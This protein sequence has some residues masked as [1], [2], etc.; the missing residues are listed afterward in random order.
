MKAGPY[1]GTFSANKPAGIAHLTVKNYT[2]RIVRRWSN[3]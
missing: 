1:V 2:P 3:R